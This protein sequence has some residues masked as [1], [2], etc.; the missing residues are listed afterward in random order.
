MWTRFRNCADSFEQCTIVFDG[1]ADGFTSAL[2]LKDLLE[3]AGFA[4][5]SKQLLPLNHFE[6]AQLQMTEDRIWFFVDLQPPHY[7]DHVFCIDHHHLIRDWKTYMP[8]QYKQHFF[9]VAP[10]EEMGTEP[11]AAVLLVAYFA[12]IARGGTT[13]YHEFLAEMGWAKNAMSAKLVMLG[14]ISDNLWLLRT[15]T[16]NSLR[17]WVRALGFD[18]HLLIKASVAISLILGREEDRMAG[19]GP[20]IAREG[21]LSNTILEAVVN[22]LPKKTANLF[23]FAKRVDREAR[24]FVE[25]RVREVAEGIELCKKQI[26]RDARRLEQYERAMPVS[27][28]E[29]RQR[30]IEM[31]ETVG[32][33][34][35]SKW[36]QIEFYGKEIDR[37]HKSLESAHNQLDTLRKRH[38]QIGP[39]NIRGIAVFLPK[40]S[41]DQVKGIL[42]SLLYYFGQHNI[43][44]E[45]RDGVAVW[46]A[47]GYT[48]AELEQTLT[49]L[50]FD[51]DL[52]N[53]YREIENASQSLPP[54]LRKAVN[55]ASFVTFEERYVAEGGG[56][57][58]V[59]GGSIKGSVPQLFATIETPDLEEKLRELMA[60]GQLARAL[61]GL[62]EGESLIPTAQAV[63]AKLKTQNWVTIQIG[64][65]VKSGDILDGEWGM[66]IAWLAG[67]KRNIGPQDNVWTVGS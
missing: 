18:E 34:S 23:N 43:V 53:T 44:I 3:E 54:M 59:F 16:D 40:Q 39:N 25:D 58:R 11:T 5:G 13:S 24:R 7:A 37:L 20:V 46:G 49:T 26:E 19:L 27:L 22:L 9:I 8:P 66:I 6:L 2:V 65:G 64:S 50:T 28:R 51:R 60:H 35:K 45:E 33:R 21:K 47:R 36:K 63:R 38:A 17:I 12:H 52:L 4:I 30:M 56:R 61:K 42:A 1:D 41:S 10:R 62:T 14:T 15:R 29:N 32:D 48:K 31:L 57:G 67:A 55:I